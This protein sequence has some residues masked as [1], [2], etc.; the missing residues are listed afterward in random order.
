[1]FV[2]LVDEKAGTEFP[3]ILTEYTHDGSRGTLLVLNPDERT[4]TFEP[5]IPN[6][7]DNAYIDDDG[8]HGVYFRP[9]DPTNFPSGSPEIDPPETVEPPED[10]D[11]DQ[12]NTEASF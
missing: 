5:R 10:D 8:K 1:M 7:P 9:G 11:D 2:T 4:V 12:E 3:A 6:G